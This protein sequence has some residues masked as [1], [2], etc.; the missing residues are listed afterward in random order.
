VSG[1]IIVLSPDARMID[2]SRMEKCGRSV[3]LN[4]QMQTQI[5]AFFSGGK[6]R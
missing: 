1:K 5:L 4:V 2:S 3:M 6:A